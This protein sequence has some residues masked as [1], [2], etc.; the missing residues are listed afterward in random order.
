MVSDYS[1]E[2]DT[3]ITAILYD[4]PEDT[5]LTKERISCEFG[6]NITEQVLAA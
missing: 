1:S 5:R 3:I 2:T 6:N 4:T